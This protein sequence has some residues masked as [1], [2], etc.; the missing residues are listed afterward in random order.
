MSQVAL[1]MRPAQLRVRDGGLSLA[2]AI[3]SGNGEGPSGGDDGCRLEHLAARHSPR[4]RR[5]GPLPPRGALSSSK[6]PV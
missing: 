5:P 4:A 6:R 2:L 1:E 3:T